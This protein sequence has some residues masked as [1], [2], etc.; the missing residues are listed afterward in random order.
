MSS[1]TINI[2]FKSKRTTLTLKLIFL[3]LLSAVTGVFLKIKKQDPHPTTP[4]ILK[5]FLQCNFI[6]SLLQPELK[7]T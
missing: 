3:L 2:M 7:Q 1:A 4:Y 6:S 5:K